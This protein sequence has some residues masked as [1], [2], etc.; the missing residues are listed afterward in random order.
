[1]QEENKSTEVTPKKL[2]ADDILQA[3]ETE[4]LTRSQM[5]EKM[6]TSRAALNR[7]LDPKNESVT[8][9]TLTKAAEVLDKKLVLRLL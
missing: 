5:A 9:S 2:I 8:L 6:H 1:M 4:H 7:L 3:M